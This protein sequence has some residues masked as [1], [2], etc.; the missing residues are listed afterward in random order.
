[1]KK[2]KIQDN[3]QGSID[4][5]YIFSFDIQSDSVPTEPLLHKHS[6]FIYIL[7]GRGKI[8]IQNKIIDLLPGVII[9][10]APWQISEIVEVSQELIYYLLVYNFNLINIYV[11]KEFNIDSENINIINSLY[12]SNAVSP[13]AKDSLKIKAVFEDIK[14]EFGICS[15]NLLSESKQYSTLYGISKFAE[16]L[17]LYLRNIDEEFQKNNNDLNPDMIFMYM[18]LNCC[19]N[20]NLELISKAFFMSESSISKYIK[21][22][23]G[24]GFYDLLNEMRLFKA[25]FLLAHTNLTVKDIAYILN[26]SD[27]GQLSKIF[28][29]RYHL[30]TKDFKKLQCPESLV[31]I[32][33]DYR[34]LKIIE[35]M[36]ENY[37]EELD[38]VS[39]SN[40]F[41]IPPKNINHILM[42]YIEKNFYNF[43]NQIRIHKACDLLTETD[44]SITDISAMVGYNSTKT[45]SR[46]FTKILNLTPSEF[47]SSYTK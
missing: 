29:E 46:N 3:Y 18:F 41:K 45:F 23:T 4:D 15:I 24:V 43:L 22:L 26:Y 7:E 21:D 25:K 6:R 37:D 33:L 11:K 8:K 1:M 44:L 35:Y 34:G 28:Q 42:Y 31:N 12:M 13:S 40:Q 20:L 32:R 38:I 19:N 2:I 47:R 36:Y 5:N 16:L 27:P 17:V 30:G 10:I 39:V 9:S 14:D